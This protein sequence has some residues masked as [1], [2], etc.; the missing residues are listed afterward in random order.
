M[1]VRFLGTLAIAALGFFTGTLVAHHS[2]EAYFDLNKLLVLKGIVSSVSWMNPHS[3]MFMDV[4]TCRVD[5][6]A[7]ELA[8]PPTMQRIGLNRDTLK[9]GMAI[10]ILSAPAKRDSDVSLPDVAERAK[11]KHFVLGG[12]V[13]LSSGDKVQN[14]EGPECP[15]P[16][17][18]IPEEGVFIR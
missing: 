7:V 17:R 14:P 9:P 18:T 15:K 8:S 3:Y 6:W 10:S 1:R 12:C 2:T 11:A 5:N 4:T 13:T 16:V